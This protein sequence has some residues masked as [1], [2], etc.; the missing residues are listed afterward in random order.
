MIVL[1]ENL[2]KN[3]RQRFEL[4]CFLPA[5]TR[6]DSPHPVFFF[7]FNFYSK[8]KTVQHWLAMKTKK[9]VRRPYLHFTSVQKLMCRGKVFKCFLCRLL[10]FNLQS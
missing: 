8:L 2:N 9:R 10:S 3:T 5:G 7:G 1:E 6:E 4:N